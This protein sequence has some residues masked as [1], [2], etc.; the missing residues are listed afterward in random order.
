M[1][2]DSINSM[3]EKMQM[4]PLL[5][6]LTLQ[7][8]NQLIINL[9]LDFHQY[10]EGSTIV[11]QGERC[12]SLIYIINGTFEA[13]YHDDKRALILSE[14]INTTPHLIEPYNIFGVKRTY[15]RTYTSLG[16][17]STF[18]ISREFFINKML[19]I[20]ILRS[21][22]TNYLCNNLRK[23]KE[24]ERFN[25]PKGIEQK[26]I[27]AIR[28]FCLFDNGEKNVRITMNDLADMIDETRLNVS[29]VLNKWKKNKQIELRRYGFTIKNLETLLT[30]NMDGTNRV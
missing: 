29:G 18:S 12:S 16:G 27:A 13:E 17:V 4:L 23:S 22:Y 5:Q 10:G 8:F 19:S 1:R 3:T 9:K 6:G 14:T 15:E 20:P 21:N 26:M 30:S 2:Q 24:S 11:G 28:S 25:N 7:E